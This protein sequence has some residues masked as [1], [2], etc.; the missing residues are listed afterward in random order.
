M[1]IKGKKGSSTLVTASSN[2]FP[3]EITQRRQSELMY[4]KEPLFSHGHDAILDKSEE[5]Y[6]R[7]FSFNVGHCTVFVLTL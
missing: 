7:V 4:M 1:K 2:S 3:E 6:H 5:N